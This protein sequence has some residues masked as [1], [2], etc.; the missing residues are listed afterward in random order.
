MKPCSKKGNEKVHVIWLKVRYRGTGDAEKDAA[1]RSEREDD[2]GETE[3][4][5]GQK[6]RK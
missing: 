2:R 5:H 4:S 3:A 1:D 6:K